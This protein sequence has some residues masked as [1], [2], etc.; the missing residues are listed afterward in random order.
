MLNVTMTAA[1][2]TLH[3]WWNTSVTLYGSFAQMVSLFVWAVDKEKLVP[4]SAS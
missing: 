1:S 2:V 3:V 4:E